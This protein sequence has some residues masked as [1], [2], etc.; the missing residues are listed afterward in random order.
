MGDVHVSEPRSAALYDA[1]MRAL[2]RRFFPDTRAWVGERAVG[3]TL[4]IAAGTCLN[5]PH[6]PQEVR[7]EA[8]DRNPAMLTLGAARAEALG[9]SLS[10]KV[11]DALV[12]PFTD[13]TFDTVVCTFALC[14]V[15]DVPAA[16][17][18]AG[19]VLRPGGRLLLAD[20]VV[21]STSA[22]RRVQRAVEAVT[23]PLAGEHFTRRPRQHLEDAGFDL[24][25]SD[26]L[27]HGAIER[28][29]ARLR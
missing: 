1:M 16:L 8:L 26:R 23:I 28:L 9:R 12:L 21:A 25:E 20:H 7:L 13:G 27:A 2:E 22:V 4:E 11:G 19:R 29:H 15:R 10:T 5:L 3:D 24:V 6:Y 18:E 17:A 14:E